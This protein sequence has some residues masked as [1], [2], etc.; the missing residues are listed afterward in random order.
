MLILAVTASLVRFSMWPQ[1]QLCWCEDLGRGGRTGWGWA[2][3]FISSTGFCWVKLTAKLRCSC[4]ANGSFFMHKSNHGFA[5]HQC[6]QL[7]QEPESQRRFSLWLMWAQVMWWWICSQD[8][9]T[10]ACSRTPLT[11]PWWELGFGSGANHCVTQTCW[12]RVRSL[13][14]RRLF[15]P[16]TY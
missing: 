2:A 9:V 7:S 3:A 4:L 5:S 15:W 10:G 11:C 8:L 14:R 13:H 16:G 6:L 1:K 12:E